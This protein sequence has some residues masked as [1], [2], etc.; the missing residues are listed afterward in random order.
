[1]GLPKSCSKTRQRDQHYCRKSSNPAWFL[2]PP[3][4]RKLSNT[5]HWC[6]GRR[7][8]RHGMAKMKTVFL[9]FHKG[10][11][12]PSGILHFPPLPSHPTIRHKPNQ[13]KPPTPIITTHHSSPQQQ[14]WTTLAAGHSYGLSA[15]S[16]RLRGSA[17]A[18]STAARDHPASARQIREY[19]AFGSLVSVACSGRLPVLRLSRS[20]YLLLPD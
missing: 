9:P 5:I 10:S 8:C 15:A 1:L 11:P 6:L 12:V 17:R 20:Y 19:H 13:N 16:P 18:S 4:N 7:P 14:R 3:K 2:G